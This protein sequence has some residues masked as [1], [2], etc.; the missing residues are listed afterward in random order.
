VA[1]A[2]PIAQH[3]WFPDPEE[4]GRLRMWDGKAWTSLTK[5]PSPDEVASG[6]AP[7]GPVPRPAPRPA[8]APRTAP[9][10][11]RTVPPAALEPVAPPT[12][13]PAPL[14][15]ADAPATTVIADNIYSVITLGLTLVY[16][17][18]ASI[19]GLVVA[20]VLPVLLAG[21]AFSVREPM[22]PF[23]GLAA[24]AAVV[25]GLVLLTK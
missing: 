4:P 7:D 15:A 20:G 6:P 8:P 21:R 17:L 12:A 13:I 24:V 2:E 11:P 16:I 1:R 5:Y 9:L 25:I 18:V 14:D 22:A 19:T 10:A 3:G 23:A